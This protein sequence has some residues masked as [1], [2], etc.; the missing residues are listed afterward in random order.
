MIT[1]R[2]VYPLA[3]VLADEVLN[4]ELAEVPE[5]FRGMAAHIAALS[6]D[7]RAA[8]WAAMLAAREDR[9]ALVE[10]LAGIDPHGP[11]PPIEPPPRP[12]YK[13]IRAADI[14]ARSVEWLWMGRVPL[15]M[16]SL[17]AGDPKLGKSYVTIALAAAVSRGAPLPGD[18]R[19]P[20]G[21][22][23]V[24]LLSAEDDPSR[25]IVPRLKAAGAELARIHLLES[26]YLQGKEG[27]EVEALPSLRTDIDRIG[28]AAAD[29]GDCRLIVVD[30]VSAYLGGV[31]DHKNAELRGA[32]SPLKALAERLAA[33]VVLV[34]HLNKGVGNNGKHRVTGSIAYVGACRANALFVRDRDDPSGRRVLMLDN[35]GNLAP[36]QPTLA[37]RIED[38]GDGPAV[39]WESEPVPITAEEALRAEQDDRDPERRQ[40]RRDCDHWLRGTLANGPM[41]ADEIYKAGKDAGF[42][43]SALDRSKHCIGAKTDRDGFG[44]GSKCYWNLTGAAQPAEAGPSIDPTDSS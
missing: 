22:A 43:R 20:A 10:A 34:S 31:D 4:G 19:A 16:L 26:V 3:R 40:E 13:R 17:W 38:R 23:S 30:P 24:L 28:Q 32:L 39:E 5:P 33:A 15:G 29:L 2:S 37:F 25:T 7:D 27:A 12:P 9:D 44:P 36:A 1:P 8:A 42:S 6:P 11:P 21:P 18:D 14:I 35:G 41:L